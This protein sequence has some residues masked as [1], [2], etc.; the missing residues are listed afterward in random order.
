MK[1]NDFILQLA[2]YCEINEDDLTLS[3]NLK[4]LKEYDSLLIMSI[5]AFID[6]KFGKNLRA[7]Q[8]EDITDFDSLISLI[9]ID[10]FEKE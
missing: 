6:E 1:K 2:E 4:S 5:I 10:S 7:S 9:G 8:I 3:T